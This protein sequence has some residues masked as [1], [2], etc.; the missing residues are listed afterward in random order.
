MVE[1]KD[2][3]E[4]ELISRTDEIKQ[5]LEDLFDENMK[6][7]GWDVPEAD[8]Q[9]ASEIL[10]DILQSKLDEIREDVKSGKYE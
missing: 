9:E 7:T 3:I 5:S 2:M 1:K 10:V 6:I 4:K 8:T